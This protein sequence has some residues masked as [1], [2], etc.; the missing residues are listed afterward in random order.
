MGLGMLWL[1][2]HGWLVLGIATT[3]W[4]AA[5]TLFAVR[6]ARWTQSRHPVLPPLDWDA[7]QTFSPRDREAWKLVEEAA[8]EG[9]QLPY[10]A[11]LEADTYINSGRQMFQRLAKHYHPL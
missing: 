4:V 11:L 10:G 3:F 1:W 7:P 2:E 8:D 9:D 6:A 5:G